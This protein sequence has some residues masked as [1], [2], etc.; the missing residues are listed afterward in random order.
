M[1]DLHS[2]GYLWRNWDFG[3][4][5]TPCDVNSFAPDLTDS[6]MAPAGALMT[7]LRFNTIQP[8]GGS[9][10]SYPYTEGS[11][12]FSNS[13]LTLEGNF[14]SVSLSS[15]SSTGTTPGSGYGYDWGFQDWYTNTTTVSSNAAQN[16]CSLYGYMQY[17]SLLPVVLPAGTYA[18]GASLVTWFCSNLEGA[19]VYSCD[20]LEEGGKYCGNKQHPWEP[21]GTY[22][23][24][25]LGIQLYGATVSFSNTT[26]EMILGPISAYSNAGDCTSTK[27]LDQTTDSSPYWSVPNLE[28]N[29]SPSSPS[30]SSHYPPPVPWGQADIT[31]YAYLQLFKQVYGNGNDSDQPYS[32][33]YGVTFENTNTPPSPSFVAGVSIWLKANRL[34]IGVFTVPTLINTTA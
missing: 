10:G 19:E 8:S 22:V 11:C 16:S 15:S 17:I 2:T 33:G 5:T 18:V 34:A 30:F 9:C 1:L 26:G 4:I 20:D 32:P 25:V 27:W 12:W 28:S 29:G 3:E 31:E 14:A 23:G 24:D 6:I 21:Q 13:F 7:S